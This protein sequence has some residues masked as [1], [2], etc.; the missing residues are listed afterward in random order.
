MV[1][2]QVF[3]ENIK[4]KYKSTLLSKATFLS[5]LTGITSIVVPYIIAC[6][7]DGMIFIPKTTLYFCMPEKYF[8]VLD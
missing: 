6:K 5:L 3:S 8:R 7:T 2:L 4:I 1:V